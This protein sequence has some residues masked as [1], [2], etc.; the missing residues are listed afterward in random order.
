MKGSMTERDEHAQAG[1]R[2]CERCAP[3]A[4]VTPEKKRG[5]WGLPGVATERAGRCLY[6]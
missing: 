1:K 5:L 2:G 6:P 3:S 4:A